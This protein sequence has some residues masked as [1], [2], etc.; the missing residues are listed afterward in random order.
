MKIKNFHVRC[1]YS[2]KN[3][4]VFD[5]HYFSWKL[6]ELNKFGGDGYDISC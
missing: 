1:F 4:G 6:A 3:N 2:I 5:T